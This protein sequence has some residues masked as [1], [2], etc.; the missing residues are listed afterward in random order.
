MMASGIEKEIE[1]AVLGRDI[2]YIVKA[3]DGVKDNIE[4]IKENYV[5][6]LE[7]KPVQKTVYGLVGII[8]VAVAGAVVSLV[9]N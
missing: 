9:V 3:I 7:F 2:K 4:D 6:S 5:T 1:L 8:L